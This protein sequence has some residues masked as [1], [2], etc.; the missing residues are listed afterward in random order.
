M[1]AQNMHIIMK[2]VPHAALTVP[3]SVAHQRYRDSSKHAHNHETSAPCCANCPWLSGTPAAQNMHINMKQVPHAALTV[4]GSVAH[5][6]YRDSSKHAY[7]HETSAHAALTVPGSVAHQRY[8]D[9][10]KHAHNH[11]TSAPCCANCPWL[12]GTPKIS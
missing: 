12:S 3:G 4:P 9:S 8:H 1:T 11:E 6:R 5:Q 2:Q 7:N 10:S